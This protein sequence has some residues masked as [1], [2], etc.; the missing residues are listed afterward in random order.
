MP[1]GI[2][3]KWGRRLAAGY[4]RIYEAWLE[5]FQTKTGQDCTREE[6][7]GADRGLLKSAEREERLAY[8]RMLEQTARA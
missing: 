6:V 4:K 1:G 8:E 7:Q 5:A 2:S 3:I